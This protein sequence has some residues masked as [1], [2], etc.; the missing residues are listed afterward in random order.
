MT[1]DILKLVTL[2]LANMHPLL[3]ADN[4]PD[5]IPW[6]VVWVVTGVILALSGEGNPYDIEAVWNLTVSSR[7][8]RLLKLVRMCEQR[9][10]LELVAPCRAPGCGPHRQSHWR[11]TMA[12]ATRAA[13]GP[14]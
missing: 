6:N 14:R 2:G 11:Q 5:P 13:R 8:A 3:F 1:D 12:R 10:A 4:T 9:E 7:V